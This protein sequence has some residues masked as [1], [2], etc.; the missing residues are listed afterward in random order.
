LAGS[1]CK[2][3]RGI[4]LAEGDG[5][6]PTQTPLSDS[7]IFTKKAGEAGAGASAVV[8]MPSTKRR[9]VRAGKYKLFG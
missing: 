5:T 4:E 1:N 3:S 2:R 7:K 8:M 6:I 9:L